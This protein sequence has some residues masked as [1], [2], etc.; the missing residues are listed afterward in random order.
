MN[1]NINFENERIV[2]IS[3]GCVY[4]LALKESGRV[5]GWGSNRSGQLG[6]DVKPSTEPIIIE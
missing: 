1:Y 4:S 5:F 6:V 2:M 3:Y